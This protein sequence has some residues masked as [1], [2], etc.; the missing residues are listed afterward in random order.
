MGSIPG[1]RLSQAQ[2][3]GHCRTLCVALAEQKIQNI[4]VA[5]REKKFTRDLIWVTK[6]LAILLGMTLISELAA[7][8]VLSVLLLIILVGLTFYILFDALERCKEVEMRLTQ[9]ISDMAL[10]T[11]DS[12]NEDWLTTQYITHNKNLHLAV[13]ENHFLTLSKTLP[14]LW[15]SF[16]GNTPASFFNHKW[17]FRLLSFVTYTVTYP[18]EGVTKH[19][20]RTGVIAVISE[21]CSSE[22]WF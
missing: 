1:H 16:C 6:H 21:T 10:I 19:L 15:D 17:R 7:L 22:N 12:D 11:Q 13:D 8:R 5:L 3:L 9:E 20:N 14:I 2:I 4:R 18:S